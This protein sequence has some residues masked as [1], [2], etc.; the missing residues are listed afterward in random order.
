LSGDPRFRD[1]SD[2][3]FIDEKWVFLNQKYEK[4]YLLPDEDDPQRTAKN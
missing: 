4:Y 3:V 2:I 1:F